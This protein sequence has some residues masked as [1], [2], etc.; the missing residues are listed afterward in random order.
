MCAPI[1]PVHL[2][3]E[4]KL[5]EERTAP[6]KTTEGLDQS[7]LAAQLPK[8]GSQKQTSRRD[9]TTVEKGPFAARLRPT[10]IQCLYVDKR[11]DSITPPDQYLA[12]RPSEHQLTLRLLS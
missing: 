6:A 8:S 2:M 9:A 10:L 5:P 4:K 7:A 1:Y 3:E 12:L 11:R